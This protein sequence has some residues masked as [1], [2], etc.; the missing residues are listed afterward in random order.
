[1]RVLPLF[2]ALS[3]FLFAAADESHVVQNPV[4]ID[5]IRNT[6]AQYSLSIDSKDF[7]GFQLVFTPDAVADYSQPIGVLHGLSNIQQTLSAAL[8]NVKSQHS[9][10]TQHITLLSGNIA[11]ATTYVIASQFGVGIY[12]GQLLTVWAKY[13]DALRMDGGS[14]L[15]Y[16]RRVTFMVRPVCSLL[17]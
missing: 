8:A 6:L 16:D 10:T 2:T 5:S 1:M 15:I 17:S 4:D 7:A 13:D 11:N 3:F 12:D 9:L 14:W